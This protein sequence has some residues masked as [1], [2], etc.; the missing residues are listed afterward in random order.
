MSDVKDAVWMTPEAQE[1]L[2]RELHELNVARSHSATEGARL[3]ARIREVETLLRQAEVGSKP[4]DGLVEPGMEVTVRF[5]TD[6]ASHTFLIGTRQLLAD[7]PSITV[8]VY[9]PSSPLGEAIIGA[10]P[11]QKAS[12]LAPNGATV[13]VE[14]L[15]AKPFAP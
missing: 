14:I 11:G 13:G 3:D 15:A 6:G 5:D 2:T 8:D 12:Y 7:D 9:S 4:D 1:R 10:Y